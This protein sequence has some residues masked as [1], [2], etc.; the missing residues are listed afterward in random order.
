LASFGRAY[1]DTIVAT[2][3]SLHLVPSHVGRW[4]YVTYFYSSQIHQNWSETSRLRPK[5]EGGGRGGGIWGRAANV[6]RIPASPAAEGHQGMLKLPS[7]QWFL[8]YRALSIWRLDPHFYG[9]C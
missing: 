2:E 1:P 6:D 7:S 9:L 5:F 3:L 8:V 4:S